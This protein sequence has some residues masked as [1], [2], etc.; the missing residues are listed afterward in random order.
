MH[1]FYALQSV[2][3][4]MR[5][6][7]VGELCMKSVHVHCTLAFR[8]EAIRAERA[9]HQVVVET[10]LLSSACHAEVENVFLRLFLIEVDTCPLLREV[11]QH[12]LVPCPEASTQVLNGWKD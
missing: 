7:K 11:R 2:A 10:S 9:A 12:L 8:H 5:C 6:A 1:G 4:N 3:N